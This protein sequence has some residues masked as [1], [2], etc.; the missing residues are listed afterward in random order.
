MSKVSGVVADPMPEPGSMRV[1]DRRIV[2]GRRDRAAAGLANHDFLHREIAERLIDR[3][4]DVKRSFPLALDLGC[5]TGTLSHLIGGRGGVE[6]LVSCDLSPRMAAAAPGPALAGDEEALPFA[7]A[8]FDL[9]LSSLSLHWVND[10]PGALAQVRRALRPDGLFLAAMFGGRTLGELR[11]VLGDAEIALEGGLS[12]RISPFAEVRDAGNLLQRA[13]FA[14]PVADSETVT[15][16]YEDPLRLLA[17]LRGMGEA[18]AAIERR[19]G[20]SRRS[21]LLA[22]L[23]RYRDLYADGEGR[24]PASF[25]VITLTAWAPDPSQPKPLRR[26]SAATHLADAL[27]TPARSG[28]TKA[29]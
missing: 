20:F 7:P 26:G 24:V 4:D 13:G 12:P 11:R 29:G 9:V 22:A 14:L 5:H 16:M 3:L 6:T 25:E 23:G 27:A 8:T 1:F 10:L 18:N 2:R 15:V 28:E 17:D 21:T 19:R